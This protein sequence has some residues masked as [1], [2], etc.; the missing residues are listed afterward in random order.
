[1]ASDI[2]Y[3]MDAHIPHAVT[4][5]L[6]QR[7]G[8]VMTAQEAGLRTADDLDHLRRATEDDRVMVSQDIDFLL[9]HKAGTPH[10]GI[11]YAQQQ[12]S[13]GELVRGLMLIHDSLTAGEMRGRV[14]FLP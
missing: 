6:R 8:D 3:Y 13:I 2:K 9:L 14:E 12:T 4:R 1:M 7:G 10:A 5:G 11:V